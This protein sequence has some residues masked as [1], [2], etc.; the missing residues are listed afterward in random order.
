MAFFLSTG[1]LRTFHS[2]DRELFCR[3]V[4][5]LGRDPYRSM[6]IIALWLW[7]EAIGYPSMIQKMRK[8]PDIVVNAIAEEGVTCLYQIEFDT[9]PVPVND[10]LRLTLNLM[11]QPISL[12][13]IF[14]NRV[15]ARAVIA[16]AVNETFSRVFDDIVQ[17]RAARNNGQGKFGVGNQVWGTAD[18][19]MIIQDNG[20]TRQVITPSSNNISRQ[21]VNPG[22][23]PLQFEVG[24]SSRSIQQPDDHRKMIMAFSRGYPIAEGEVHDYFMRNYGDVVER[25][26]MEETPPNAQPL[27]AHVTFRSASAIDLVLNG[28]EQVEFVIN[29]KQVWTRRYVTKSP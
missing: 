12:R 26:R 25:I 9:P 18:G 6:Q 19:R 16:R 10:N 14:E 21:G 27:Y 24:E 29:G 3:L 22:Y 17:E 8:L 4:I 13:Y 7:L 15:R 11:R 2:I 5:N 28:T 1:E 20:Q 23:H